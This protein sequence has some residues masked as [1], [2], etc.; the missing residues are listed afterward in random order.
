M[1]S[2]GILLYSSLPS[3]SS[4]E[5]TLFATQKP[6]PSEIVLE[7]QSVIAAIINPDTAISIEPV[8][9]RPLVVFKEG[10]LS[11]NEADNDSPTGDIRSI[12]TA[13]GIANI[14]NNVL[15]SNNS[16]QAPSCGTNRLMAS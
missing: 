16:I 3:T 14:A 11:D 15:E 9:S 2:I 8:R 5:K 13:I 6:A 1:P 7:I 4:Q 10:N 12:P